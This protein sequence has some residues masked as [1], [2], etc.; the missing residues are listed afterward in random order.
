[1]LTTTFLPLCRLRAFGQVSA[2]GFTQPQY[3]PAELVLFN[4]D[5]FGM[6]WTSIGSFSLF[7]RLALPPVVVDPDAAKL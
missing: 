5:W 6:L 7:T 2:P 1:M 3:V 4:D